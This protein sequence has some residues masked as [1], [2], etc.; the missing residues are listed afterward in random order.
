M[1]EAYALTGQHLSKMAAATSVSA[2]LCPEVA[3]STG[4]MTT[5]VT[6]CR[7]IASAVAATAC[8]ASH[9]AVDCTGS[10]NM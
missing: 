2:R 6:L 7:S 5:Q 9:R 10:R 3:T 1:D 4:S 8:T